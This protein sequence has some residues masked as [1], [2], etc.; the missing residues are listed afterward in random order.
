MSRAGSARW[1]A[2]FS[3]TTTVAVGE[4][5]GDVAH[6]AGVVEVNVGDHH[7]AEVTGAHPGG[8]ERLDDGR[9]RG[10]GTGLDE[11]RP[12]PLDQ[13]AGG[14]PLHPPEQGV[15]LRAAPGRSP[16][17]PRRVPHPE[18]R[19]RWPADPGCPDRLR[20]RRGR[21]GDADGGREGHPAGGEQL[22][23]LGDVGVDGRLGLARPPRGCRRVVG[24]EVGLLGDQ[25]ADDRQLLG[26]VAAA[27]RRDRGARGR[28]ARPPAGTAS[29]SAWAT[30]STSRA[31]LSPAGRVVVL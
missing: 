20:G 9:G 18:G 24:L 27:G 25:V 19:P 3:C 7:P 21:R 12:R 16:P 1:R 14:E 23:E 11:R 28:S 30:W 5:P 15:E 2:P 4:G 8:G 22:V 10:L 29:A 31:E 13:E 6:P 17:W 26:G